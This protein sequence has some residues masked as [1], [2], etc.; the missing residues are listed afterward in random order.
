MPPGGLSPSEG[1]LT[2][3]CG[4]EIHPDPSSAERL[5]C[6]LV[7]LLATTPPTCLISVKLGH[8]GRDRVTAEAEPA[9]SPGPSPG[10]R[11]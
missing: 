10:V 5:V 9:P 6:E 11:T 2:S 1:H 8:R 7:P 4:Y 3:W